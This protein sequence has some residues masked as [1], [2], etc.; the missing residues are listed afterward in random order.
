[1]GDFVARKPRPKPPAQPA[2][3]KVNHEALPLLPAKQVATQARKRF[4]KL[5]LWWLDSWQAL[6]ICVSVTVVVSTVLG[7]RI[8][9]LTQ[10]VS[11]AEKQYVNS[12]TSGQELLKHPTFMPHKLPTYVLFK[13][14]VTRPAAYRA[15]SAV[16]AVSAIISCFF[17]LRRW[18]SLRVAVLG[19]WLLLTSA[20]LLHYARLATP[21]A[22]FLLLMPLLW[23][24]VWMYSTQ[25]R[26]LALTVL[27]GVSIVSFYIPAFCWLVIGAVVWQR[28]AI[29][30]QLRQTQ[31]W[32]RVL[33][34]LLVLVLLAPLAF[35]VVLDPKE[36]LLITG[37]PA[38]LPSASSILHNFFNIPLHLLIKGP[39]SPA[40][41][42]ARIPL[43]D[44]FST[45]MLL[46]GIYSLRY[47]LLLI[48]A[49]LVV[50]ASLILSFFIISGGL[51]T[52][53]A[54]LPVV[55]LLIAGGM[56]FMLTQWYTIFPRNPI[57]RGLGTTMLSI[58]VLL[59]SF[60]HINHYFI[61]WPHAPA[62]RSAFHQTLLK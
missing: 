23:A 11:L 59:V 12:V 39:D 41:W 47:H 58:V 33:A 26:K 10:G 3:Q 25:K 24:A 40:T 30:E 1:M 54:L 38:S 27:L 13:L 61:A 60:Y 36:L 16:I 19:C 7:F 37:L 6:L 44:I 15:V 9:A 18:Y 51:V 34:G 48:R 17:I 43:L 32:F 46:L 49:Q 21:Q 55:Y 28:A 57:A 56:A 50:A 62:S 4:R 45:V 20:W 8:G 22:S 42:L 52:S 31:W 14:G 2:T 35:A 5:R 29:L 53:L